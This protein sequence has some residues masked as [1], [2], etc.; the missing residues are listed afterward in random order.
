M[1]QTVAQTRSTPVFV[2]PALT[3][4][5][6][7]VPGEPRSHRGS[8]GFES[9]NA[10]QVRGHFRLR[11]EPLSATLSATTSVSNAS[12]D[13]AVGVDGLALV[14]GHDLVVE[15]VRAQRAGRAIRTIRTVRAIGTV[16][17]GRAYGSGSSGQSRGTHGSSRA[18]RSRRS[19]RPS[20]A[21]STIVAVS[22][23][24]TR[25]ALRTDTS[26]WPRRP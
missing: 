15:P 19:R 17:A 24:S 7:K 23:V 13:L 3:T 6:P 2:D 25:H 12:D 11:A 22:T 16:L 9:L 20:H 10:H 1:Q 21:R 14:N 4:V 26:R 18:S 8:G 5:S